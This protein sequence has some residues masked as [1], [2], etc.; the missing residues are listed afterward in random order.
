MNNLSNLAFGIANVDASHDGMN[1]KQTVAVQKKAESD[2]AS[3]DAADSERDFHK[4]ILGVKAQ[5]AAQ[6]G[7]DSNEYQS[8]GLKKKSEYNLGRRSPSNT[9]GGTP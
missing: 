9:S 3:D 2:G 7:D 5:V 4:M 6:Y 8:L 1:A